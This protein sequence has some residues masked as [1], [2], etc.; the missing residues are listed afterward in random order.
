MRTVKNRK[1]PGSLLMTS[2]LLLLA[3][4]LLLTGYNLLDELRAGVS[5]GQVVTQ[6]PSQITASKAQLE[7]GVQESPENVPDSSLK[8]PDVAQ[9]IPDYV[10]A[11]NQEMPNKEI[12]GNTY[13]GVLEIPVQGLSLPIMSDWSYP[14]LRMA[15]CR[16]AG[17]AYQCGFVIAGHNYRKHFGE[18]SHLIPGDRVIFTDV[19]GT[20]FYYQVAETQILEPTE[21][22]EMT[23]KDWDLSLFTCTFGGQTRLTVRCD[24]VEI[25][26]L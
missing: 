7:P 22:E 24:R 21:V 3:A 13:I 23:S 16:Y 1:R 2:G 15:P 11:P 6:L 8:A 20:V 14:K 9:E 10:L 12:D 4:A 26:D 18:L 5:V 17:S 19:D 25:G